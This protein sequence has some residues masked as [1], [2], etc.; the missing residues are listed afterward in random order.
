MNTLLRLWY[1][2]PVIPFIWG[3]IAVLRVDAARETSRLDSGDLMTF[4]IGGSLLAAACAL[5][6]LARRLRGHATKA[7]RVTG[8]AVT[9]LM[10]PTWIIALAISILFAL[11]DG[12]PL[13]FGC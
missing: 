6:P 11:L 4:L 8:Y 10:V 9:S 12:H 2:L 1:A 13:R 3:W 5:V 7:W